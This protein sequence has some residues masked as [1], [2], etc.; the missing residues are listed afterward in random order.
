[1]GREGWQG[2]DTYAPFYDWENAQTLSRTLDVPFWRRIAL[3]A[4]RR[5][6]ARARLRHR[7]RFGAAR[8]GGRRS[9]RRLLLGADA[10]RAQQRVGRA[11]RN[12]PSAHWRSAISAQPSAILRPCG[13]SRPCRSSTR[14]FPMVLAP[15]R[16][17]PRSAIRPRDLTAALA[18]VARVIE[19]GG[20]F[21]IDLV[22]DVPK[23]REDPHRVPARGRIEI[24]VAADPDRVGQ[25]GPPPP[26]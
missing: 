9:H 25:A 11:W 14:S 4:G 7:T 20:T 2:W 12:Q 13:H 21:G 24:G 6:G 1:M 15:V 23:W 26:P 3:R 10:Q 16:H 18:S 19:L 8:Q 17:S 5:I 22:P